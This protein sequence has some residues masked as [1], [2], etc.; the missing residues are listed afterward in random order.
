MAQPQ[1]VMSDGG[2]TGDEKQTMVD[3]LNKLGSGATTPEHLKQLI[4]LIHGKQQEV[5]E[6]KQQNLPVQEAKTEP[7]VVKYSNPSDDDLSQSEDENVEPQPT[8]VSNPWVTSTIKPANNNNNEEDEEE[9]EEEPYENNSWNGEWANPAV[10]GVVEP[11]ST[12]GVKEHDVAYSKLSY[13]ARKTLQYCEMCGKYYSGDMMVADGKKNKDD[14]SNCW[15]CFFWLNYDINNRPVCDG[16][17]GMTIVE[18]VLKCHD[19]HN[20][21]SCTRRSDHGGCFL[22]EYK[23]DF[24]IIEIRDGHLLYEQDA[25]NHNC[26]NEPEKDPICDEFTGVGELVIDL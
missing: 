26:Y 5:T 18:Y 21:A 8:F 23:M 9:E 12:E 13:A 17:F 4:N 20:I 6:F 16:V 22:C 14:G 10:A 7:K 19:E 2:L 11:L 3:I 24:P 25:Q 15:H 1:T